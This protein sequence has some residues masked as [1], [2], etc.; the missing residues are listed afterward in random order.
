MARGQA[1]Q[2]TAV[3][4][5]SAKVRGRVHGD[6]DLVVHGAVEGDVTIRGDLTVEASGKLTSPGGT[7]EADAVTVLGTL[8]GDVTARGVIHVAA[9]A[10]LTGDVRGESL[11]IDEGAEFAGRV[12]AEFDLPPELGGE[13]KAARRR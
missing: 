9:G 1:S 12:E 5:A 11:A 3:I 13:S 2:S 4:G 8:E 7:V 10:K 6:G